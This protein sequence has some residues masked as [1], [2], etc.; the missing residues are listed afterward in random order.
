M[1]VSP[2]LGSDMSLKLRL[3]ALHK[4]LEQIRAVDQAISMRREEIQQLYERARG[5]SSVQVQLKMIQNGLNNS[6]SL[7]A[8]GED[9]D[10]E[11]P[12]AEEIEAALP[13]VIEEL[14]GAL[15][16]T[17]KLIDATKVMSGVIGRMEDRWKEIS[18]EGLREVH[19]ML[20]N[21]CDQRIK[22]V[23]QIEERLATHEAAGY[24]PADLWREYEDLAFRD[25]EQLFAGER[26]FAE[27]VD[28]L[29][30]LA[31][32]NTGIDQGICHMA[33]ELL[34]TCHRFGGMSL[35]HSMTVPSRRVA[36]ETTLARMIRM[37]F[38][39]W[40]IW[41]VPLGAHEYGHMVVGENEQ[42]KS[43]STAMRPSLPAVHTHLA[44]CF[45][46]YFMGP[47]YAYA[48]ILLALDPC[49]GAASPNGGAHGGGTEE[50][51]RA[52]V[53]LEMLRSID[54][55][56]YQGV[57]DALAA[58]W[59]GALAAF[60]LEFPPADAAAR[61][62]KAVELMHEFLD[63]AAP[64]LQYKAAQWQ[65]VTAWPSLVGTHRS[66]FPLE[67]ADDIRDIIN[68]AWHQRIRDEDR[69][70]GVAADELGRAAQELWRERLHSSAGLSVFGTRGAR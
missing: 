28:F 25:G 8:A 17:A 27:Y 42:L 45:A 62:G 59:S 61:L 13:Q 60:G 10:A 36:P 4:S 15:S 49:A 37:G 66:D 6:L 65:K 12:T 41:A 7:I 31:L 38:P 51:D 5:A 69:A 16:R 58:H 70:T 55:A 50:S 14:R 22:K 26:L 57:C 29:G 40:T 19:T 47:S 30:G 1:A 32:R 64:H 23:R 24:D 44:D 11:E 18:I 2:D 53:I 21:K 3:D 67:P 39:E 54:A 52:Y 9:E 56:V 63:D 68:A 35:W 20:H 33:D 46:A 34:R 48:T 43:A